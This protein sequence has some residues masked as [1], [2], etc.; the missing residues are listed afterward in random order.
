[1]T[2]EVTFEV[3][4]GN[5]TP[6]MRGLRKRAPGEGT[7]W[8]SS[9]RN[10]PAGTWRKQEARAAEAAGR[11]R[12]PIGEDGL[13]FPKSPDWHPSWHPECLS[14]LISL[15][16]NFGLEIVNEMLYLSNRQ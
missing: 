16:L 12:G 3:S 2:G 1:M 10:P 9:G 8:G 7:V 13:L 6:A 11:G 5:R 15:L 14:L 4:T